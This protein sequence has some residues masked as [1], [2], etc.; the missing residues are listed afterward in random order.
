MLGFYRFYQVIQPRQNISIYQPF[1]DSLCKLVCTTSVEVDDTKT[2]DGGT[3]SCRVQ[4]TVV[5]PIQ[6][7]RESG[8]GVNHLD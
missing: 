1:L 8:H 7:D 2:S 3:P 4:L 6:Q 5:L